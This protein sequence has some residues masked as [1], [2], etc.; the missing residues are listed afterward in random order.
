MDRNR[1]PVVLVALAGFAVG[2]AKAGSSSP[3]ESSP[4]SA[5]PGDDDGGASD[6]SASPTGDDGGAG[7]ETAAPGVAL[8]FYVSD[9]FIP[10]GFMGDSTASMNA[11]TVGHD[12][13]ACKL[14]RQSGVGGDCYKVTWAPSLPDGGAAWAGVYWQ[15]PANNWGA[16]PGKAITAGATKVSFYAAGAVGGETLQLCSGGINTN[17]ASATLPYGD[18]F[19]VKQPA[20]TLTTDWTQYELSLA[21]TSYTDVLGAFCWVA[22]TNSTESITFYIDDLKWE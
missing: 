20:I 11:I 2:C 7:A 8:P 17:A 1:W 13:T 18:T 5:T 19:S 15:S 3:W 21:G 22:S 4:D 10:A 6:D 16:H 12:V 14:P 9:E